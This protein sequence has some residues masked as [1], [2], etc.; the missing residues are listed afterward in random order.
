MELWSSLRNSPLNL[1]CFISFVLFF[2][3]VFNSEVLSYYRYFIGLSHMK[4]KHIRSV[5]EA[6]G[7]GVNKKRWKHKVKEE[8]KE[9]LFCFLLNIFHS[10]DVFY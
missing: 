6:G 4:D 9:S 10:F 7:R 8:T 1:F 5:S 3:F 2:C